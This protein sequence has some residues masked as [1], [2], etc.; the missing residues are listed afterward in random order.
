MCFTCV[1]EN[2]QRPGTP[3]GYLELIVM[4]VIVVIAVI[5]VIVVIVPAVFPHRGMSIG[6]IMEDFLKKCCQIRTACFILI[7]QIKSF[8]ASADVA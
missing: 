6:T 4:I 5:A 3:A 1:S 8:Q 2:V 7:L